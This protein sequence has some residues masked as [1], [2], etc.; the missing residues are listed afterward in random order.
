[1]KYALGI[2]LF[3]LVASVEASTIPPAQTI[4]RAALVV[5]AGGGQVLTRCVSFSEPQISGADLL[6]R[7]GL[8]LETVNDPGLGEF[9]CRIEQEG[10]PASDCLCAFP[11]TYWRYWLLQ[12]DG[13]QFSAAGA[14]TRM[15]GDGDG[16]AWV[17][18]AEDTP[19]PV[20][21]FDTVCP[22]ALPYQAYL[23]L[24]RSTS[25]ER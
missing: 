10:C 19:P 4:S 13:W 14:T 1:M 17:W 8:G 16:D 21:A 5:Q 6:R 18:S 12:A 24:L 20:I 15:L 11:P 7:S 2:L 23:P 25:K 3:V 9:V 22:A